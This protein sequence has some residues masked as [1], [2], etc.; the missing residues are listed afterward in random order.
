VEYQPA[1][2]E[3]MWRCGALP[4]LVVSVAKAM[5]MQGNEAVS[6]EALLQYMLHAAPSF[7]ITTERQQFVL[8][9]LARFGGP[10]AAQLLQQHSN[11]S[12][13]TCQ[14]LLPRPPGGSE[15]LS[16]SLEAR[17]AVRLLGAAK[18]LGR[19]PLLR[20]QLEAAAPALLPAADAALALGQ[21]D[22]VYSDPDPDHVLSALELLVAL[23]QQ[24]DPLSLGLRLPGCYNPACTSLAGASEAGMALKRC[25]GC[26]IAR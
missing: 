26:K 15:S 22:I 13:G 7:A 10:A 2:L 18:Q 3:D 1:R 14:L 4:G 19:Q 17:L 12:D 20:Q 25:M 16:L 11:S 5:D 24:L 8:L 9:V 23:G 6:A 21:D